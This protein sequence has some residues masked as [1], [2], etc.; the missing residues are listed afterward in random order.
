MPGTW[1]KISRTWPFKD[2]TMKLYVLKHGLKRHNIILQI[3]ELFLLPIDIIAGLYEGYRKGHWK[4]G[5]G[6]FTCELRHRYC[7]TMVY[8]WSIRNYLLHRLGVT[9]MDP[10]GKHMKM[11]YAKGGF[12]YRSPSDI[13]SSA[14]QYLHSF[15][16][17]VRKIAR[18]YIEHALSKGRRIRA[19]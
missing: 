3:L 12:D 13:W 8:P 16:P 18:E 2:T 1:T 15:N 19:Y 7:A 17:V 10:V 6:N 14:T 9:I 4:Y 5:F 11:F